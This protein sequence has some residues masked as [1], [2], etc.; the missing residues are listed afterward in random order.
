MRNTEPER[1]I[2]M[3]KR[4]FLTLIGRQRTPE[5]DKTVTELSAEAQCSGRNGALYLLYEEKTQDGGLVRNRIKYR[6][7]LLELT[8]KGAVN[9]HM[10][11]EPGREHM[12]DY[13][14]PLG[15][16]RFGVRTTAV[17]ADCQTDQARIS[18]RYTLTDQGEPVSHC[19]IDIL[20]QVRG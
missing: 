9:T 1:Y 17:E 12:T 19:E 18:A 20:V 7:P 4:V 10:I 15:L 3:E 8:K 5:G 6:K 2:S 11:F 13:A 14:T 16:L